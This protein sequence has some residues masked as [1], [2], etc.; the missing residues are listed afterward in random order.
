MSWGWSVVV[1]GEGD[2]GVVGLPACVSQMTML[3]L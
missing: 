2:G 3:S 1:S